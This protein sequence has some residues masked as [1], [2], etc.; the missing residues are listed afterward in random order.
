MGLYLHSTWLPEFT[1]LS[2]SL[3]ETQL[4]KE[5]KVTFDILR[6]VW[7]HSWVGERLVRPI[8]LLC[9]SDVHIPNK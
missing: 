1:M 3:R 5:M 7:D 4:V 2:F 6:C 8:D 9:S